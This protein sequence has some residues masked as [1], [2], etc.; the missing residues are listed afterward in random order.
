MPVH[1]TGPSL[2]CWVYW[3]SLPRVGRL[4]ALWGEMGVSSPVECHRG[5]EQAVPLPGI[6][7]TGNDPCSGPSVLT[8]ELVASQLSEED[9]VSPA[10]RVTLAHATDARRGARALA[11]PLLPDPVVLRDLNETEP[12]E[13][14]DGQQG[15][16]ELAPCLVKVGEGSE[17]VECREE[18]VL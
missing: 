12:D 16:E 3:G 8:T 11:L 4:P 10:Q 14:I 1:S 5:R 2:V 7:L 6:N 18:F 17:E 15:D 9:K 13:L